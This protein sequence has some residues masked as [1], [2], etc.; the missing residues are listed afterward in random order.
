MIYMLKRS[1]LTGDL[2]RS[3][4]HY[5][6]EDSKLRATSLRERRGGNCPN[7]LEVLQQL[8]RDEDGLHAFLVS[9]L[10]EEQ[11]PATRRIV[12]SFGEG[13]RINFDHCLCRSGYTEAASSYVIRSEE[14]GSRTLVNYNNLPDITLQEFQEVLQRFS[15]YGEDTWWHFEVS[16]RS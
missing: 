14:S 5:P 2:D 12:A 15:S 9:S 6:E 1:S 7:S 16:G 10:P 4:P 8:V 3:V 13:T 11:S